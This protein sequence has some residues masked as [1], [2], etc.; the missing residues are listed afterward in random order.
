MSNPS[1]DCEQAVHLTLGSG[2]PRRAELLRQLGLEFDVCPPDIDETPFE[3]E[4]PRDYV[5]RMSR[6][7]AGALRQSF[8]DDRLVLCADT[9][10]TVDGAILGKPESK[11]HFAQMLMRLSGREH[12]VLTA[13]TVSDG[14]AM[15]DVVVETIVSFRPLT[16]EE[17]NKYWLTGEPVDKAGGYGI[18]GI[19]ALFVH[20]I[21]GSYSNVVGLPLMETA[22]LLNASG[23]D[24]LSLRA[25]Q[26]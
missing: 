23:I 2:S 6:S 24:C 12:Q 13:V 26:R 20:S 9:T 15:R 10:V 3:N 17:C 11:A 19:G 25:N 7:K 14:P 21:S 1:P 22:T 16:I 8:G 5:A 4:S 18:Q